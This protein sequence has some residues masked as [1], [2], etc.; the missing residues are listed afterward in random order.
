M[1]KD[2]EAEIEKAHKDTCAKGSDTYADPAT[3]AAVFTKD[4]LLKQGYCCENDCRHCPYN[5]KE[6]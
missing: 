2:L 5:A 3:G 1:N 4:F 6:K